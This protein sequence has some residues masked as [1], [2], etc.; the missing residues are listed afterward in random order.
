ML[1]DEEQGRVVHVTWT[2]VRR[3]RKRESRKRGGKIEQGEKTQC[4]GKMSYK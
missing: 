1:C 4:W 2:L 3:K